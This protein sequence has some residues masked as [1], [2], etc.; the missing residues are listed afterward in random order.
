MF[1]TRAEIKHLTSTGFAE[2]Q[3]GDL[4]ESMHQVL[5][6]GVTAKDDLNKLYRKMRADGAGMRRRVSVSRVRFA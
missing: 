6:G 3:A 2:S 5:A 4:T 1:D